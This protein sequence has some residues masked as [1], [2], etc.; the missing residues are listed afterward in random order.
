MNKTSTKAFER[1]QRNSKSNGNLNNI[2]S[3]NKNK[4]DKAE[5]KNENIIIPPPKKLRKKI[6]YMSDI[7]KIGFSG[8]SNKKVN[9]DAFFIH[10]NFS[11]DSN[12]TYMAVW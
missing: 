4:G 11:N 6:L 12:C 10:K 8:Q 5:N 7:T 2:L 1:S 3:P 9:Q